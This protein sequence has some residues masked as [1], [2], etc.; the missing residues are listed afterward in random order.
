MSLEKIYTYFT[1]ETCTRI[2]I[3][4]LIAKEKKLENT[5]LLIHKW[6]NNFSLLIWDIQWQVYLLTWKINNIVL[7]GQ[8]WWKIKCN[9]YSEK[10]ILIDFYLTGFKLNDT[11]VSLFKTFQL[12]LKAQLHLDTCKLFSAEQYLDILFVWKRWTVWPL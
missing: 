11:L 4:P 12:M 2:F 3:I 1:K 8:T 6:L 9:R 5:I 7:I 10:N